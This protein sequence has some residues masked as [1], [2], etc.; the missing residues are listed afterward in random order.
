MEMRY[1]YVKVRGKDALI[2]QVVECCEGIQH[3]MKLQDHALESRHQQGPKLQ[4]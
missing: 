2:Y 1:S 4:H 3:Y